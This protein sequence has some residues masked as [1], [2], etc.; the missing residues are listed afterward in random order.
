MPRALPSASSSSIKM[1]RGA[2][3]C[4]HAD[5]LRAAD[6][7]EG[8]AYLGGYRLGEQP[9]AGARIAHDL[10][11]LRDLAAEAADALRSAQELHDFLELCFRFVDSRDVGEAH[12]GLR[13]DAHLC[14]ARS[15]STARTHA[16]PAHA[17]AH[18]W[19]LTGKSPVRTPH[20]TIQSTAEHPAVRNEILIRLRERHG[21]THITI[22]FDE[23]LL[24]RCGAL[25]P[26]RRAGTPRERRATTIHAQTPKI[27]IKAVLIS[28]ETYFH[29]KQSQLTDKTFVVSVDFALSPAQKAPGHC[30]CAPERCACTPT[31]RSAK[32]TDRANRGGS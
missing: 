31:W 3:C 8:H 4:G 17:F 20:A 25:G 16:R 9:L 23:P 28:F 32:A 7:E 19:S 12:T 22:H 29:R 14:L 26:R 1:V 2:L 27:G 15:D 30:L 5:E 10:H 24:T 6:R 18:L 13:L 21:I 11:A